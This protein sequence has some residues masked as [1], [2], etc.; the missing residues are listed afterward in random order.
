MVQYTGEIT[1][2]SLEIIDKSLKIHVINNTKM[3]E[4]INEK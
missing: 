3:I 2:D 4:I 1:V